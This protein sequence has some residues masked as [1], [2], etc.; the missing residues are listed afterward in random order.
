MTLMELVP[1]FSEGRELTKIKT[2][3]AYITKKANIILLGM[4][5]GA[6]V[7]RSVFT[8][9]G[10]K[11]EIF[12]AACAAVEIAAN[13][14]DMNRQ[15]GKHLRLGALDVCPFI[16]LKN[17][18]MQE[19]AELAK[20][21]AK[22]AGELGIPAYLY[23]A[24]ASN[25][26]RQNLAYIRKG[27]YENLPEK[28]KTLTPDFG[29]CKFNS[30]VKKTGAFCFGARNF[31]IAYNINLN[32][33]DLSAAKQ[34]AKI[35]RAK[36]PYIKTTAWFIKEYDLCQVSINI[37][38][39]QKAPMAFVFKECKKE[40]AK[41]NLQAFSSELIGFAPQEALCQNPADLDTI[42]K[43]LGLAYLKPF[44]K[45]EHIIPRELL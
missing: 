7:N 45:E 6:D 22:Y 21:T 1:N 5:S 31:L 17:A 3:A 26:E 35:L 25:F 2:I 42:I 24:A 36:I 14:I 39:Y 29:P 37:E 34:L 12:K 23:G 4:E 13:L 44:K 10:T 11:E 15:T 41:L 20:K 8:F 30:Q 40:A 18:T 32:T 19:A 33:K 9:V 28:L 38:D 16:P 43:E 27:Q